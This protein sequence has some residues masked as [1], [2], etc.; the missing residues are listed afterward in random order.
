MA[1]IRLSAIRKDFG[2]ATVLRNVTFQIAPREKVGLIGPNG[3]GKTTICRIITGEE[4]PTAGEVFQT[5]GLKIAY[6]PQTV[7]VRE[8]VP[9]LAFVASGRPDLED[10]I[11]AMKRIEEELNRRPEDPQLLKRQAELHEEFEAAGGWRFHPQCEEILEGLGFERGQFQQPVSSLSGGEQ[12]KAALGRVLVA[13]ADLLLLDEPT[14][15]LDLWAT[16]YL[17]ETLSRISSALLLI[18]HDRYLLD[19]VVEKIVALS[20]GETETYPGNWTAYEKERR[21]RELQ[22]RRAY[23]KQQA[24]IKKEEDFIRRYHAGQ[25]AAEARG[26]RRKLERIERVELPQQEK[27]FELR[28]PAAKEKSHLLLRMEGVAKRFGERILFEDVNLTINR[29]DR[30]G[31]VGPNGSGKTT[32]LRI[33]VGIEEPT[34]GKVV[35]GKVAPAYFDQTGG[36]LDPGKTVLEELA[37]VKPKEGLTA[38]RA[39]AGRFLFTGEDVFK[40]VGRLSGGEKA[41]LALAK[42][43]LTEPSFLVLDEPTNHLDISARQAVEEALRAFDGSLLLVT[44]D[45]RLLDNVIKRLLVIRRGRVIEFPG[46]WTAWRSKEEAERRDRK[47]E[48][49]GAGAG[50]AQA[51]REL[52]KRRQ[53]EERRRRRLLEETEKLIER[54]EEERESLL[55][56]F[57]EPALYKRPE[58]VK[59]LTER[60]RLLEKELEEAYRRWEELVNRG[61][62]S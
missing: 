30:I 23:E 57:E 41:R 46:D 18:S 25:R 59:E 28:L 56:R 19:R 37:A 11:R 40:K 62:S 13:Q 12:T 5:R 10:L 50:E 42:L 33:A 51:F 24:L 3:S 36:D 21:R 7:T 48:R 39:F 22:R 49:S 6:L 45:R 35:R 43:I 29:G 60:R 27:S 32:F 14:N 61:R 26:R 9:L 55:S 52:Q 16:S 1:L 31:L 34:A 54:L 47:A 38:L 44:H 15:Y 58:E 4:E 53:R 2:N 20:G 8:D 17:E